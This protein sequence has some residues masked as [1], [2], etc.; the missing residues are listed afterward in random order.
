MTNCYLKN[1][2]KNYKLYTMI[3]LTVCIESLLIFTAN[4]EFGSFG[5][6]AT[7]FSEKYRAVYYS[8]ISFYILTFIYSPINIY[9]NILQRDFFHNEQIVLRFKSR[10]KWFYENIK[11]S[12]MGT[13]VY[14]LIIFLVILI[15]MCIYDISFI[16]DTN[17]LINI[18]LQQM[19]ILLGMFILSIVVN[20]VYS[21]VKIR[22]LSFAIA[23]LVVALDYISIMRDI[24][25]HFLI[26]W[27]FYFYKQKNLVL[28]IPEFIYLAI[29]IVIL[30]FISLN[31][32]KKTEFIEREGTDGNR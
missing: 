13:F 7:E 16:K 11:L 21:V 1:L 27:M 29:V 17:F 25:I 19:H 22:I 28:G 24:K 26:P 12:F 30:I 3:V 31:M 10:S 15:G 4:H 6:F 2:F 20:A 5:A 23:Y 32:V 14:N 9:V 18:V 8:A